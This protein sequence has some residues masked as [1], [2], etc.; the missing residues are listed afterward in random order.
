MRAVNLIVI[1]SLSLSVGCTKMVAQ[2]VTDAAEAGQPDSFAVVTMEPDAGGA[3][4][5]SDAQNVAP[6]LPYNAAPGP[7]AIAIAPL[8]PLTSDEITVTV[9][10]DAID[11][12]SGPEALSYRYAWFINDLTTLHTSAGIPT[13]VTKRGDVWRVDVGAW[14]GQDLGEVASLEVEVLNSPP[15]VEEALLTPAG[16]DTNTVLVCS[17]DKRSDP[18]GDDVSVDYQWYANEVPLE[19][20]VTSALQPPLQQGVSYGCSVRPFDGMTYGA[21]VWSTE[22]SPTVVVS[23]DAVISFQPKSLD[24][25]TVVPGQVSSLELAILNIG[26]GPL[27]ITGVEFG[28]DSGFSTDAQFPLQIEAG[29]Q[30]VIW[31]HFATDVPG[32]KK[33]NIAFNTNALNQNATT[34]ALFGIG[35]AP[36]LQAEPAVL[37]F[38]GAYVASHHTLPITVTSCGALPATVD[39]VALIGS[40]NTPFVLDLSMG[41][42]P[43]PWVLEPW[44]SAT[45]EVRFEPTQPSPV[46]A[47]G[48]P[49]YEEASVSIASGL[50][51]LLDVDVKGFASAE[52][53]PVPII[54][55]EEGKY[56]SPGSLLHL[57]ASQSIAPGGLP[58]IISWAVTP[59]P[60]APEL[61]LLPTAESESITYQT[62]AAHLGPYLFT[63]KVFDLV[64]GEVVPSCGTASWTVTIK[65]AIPLIVEVEWETPGDPDQ[66]DVGP[67][68]GADLDLHMHQGEGSGE[69]Y[70]GDGVPDTW[71]DFVHDLYW[72]DT[73]PDWGVEG[74]ENDPMLVLEDPDGLGPERLEW[75]QPIKQETLT[76]GVH[77]WSSFE[78]GPSVATVK[79][80]HFE[81][82][83]ASFT[84]VVLDSGDLWEVGRF[85]WPKVDV[86]SSFG[87]QGGAKITSTYPNV[88]QAD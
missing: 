56:A 34:V 87:P 27:V 61:P 45:F 58:P 67:G 49:V 81:E 69:D 7:P 36:C 8:E 17:G 74:P 29:E 15:A 59:P 43:M 41:P 33:G 77:C 48:A 53:C 6:E 16:P 88:F 39:S 52:G 14:D 24:M 32:L 70:D 3:A 85:T 84:D 76:V 54:D 20:A 78:Y 82:L 5:S 46:D 42:G 26:D 66:S 51:P 47:D 44:E 71:F 83:V 31:V 10:A 22:V 68:M 21:T 28:G 11:P 25:G 79:V 13:A 19:G 86:I 40:D 30:V 18:D 50:N 55:A 1:A 75:H 63:L 80:F 35:A 12:D 2:S 4:A 38:G 9:T 57:N 23:E 37:D 65:D 62:D 60:G 64:D 73:S 72:F